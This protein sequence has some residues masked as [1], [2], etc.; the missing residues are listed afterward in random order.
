MA[1]SARSGLSCIKPTA[2]AGPSRSMGV[3]DA[4]WHLLNL[5]A[6]A[7]GLGLIAAS[8]TKL[9]WRREL[10]SVS[11]GRLVLWACAASTGALLAGL[12]LTGRDGRMLTYAAMVLGCAAALWWAGFVRRGR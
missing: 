10:A 12:V 8:A 11:W 9:L 2:D 3:L 4:I 5:F 6:P 1:A 7:V